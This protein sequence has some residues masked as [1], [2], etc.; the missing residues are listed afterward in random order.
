MLAFG[1]VVVGLWA[2]FLSLAAA[3][4]SRE[5]AGIDLERAAIERETALMNHRAAPR[6]EAGSVRNPTY[7]QGWMNRKT[8]CSGDRQGG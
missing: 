4:L 1:T 2:G 5:T 7:V 8:R 6:H 3:R